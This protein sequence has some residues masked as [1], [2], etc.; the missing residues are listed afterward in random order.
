LD[1]IKTGIVII[2]RETKNIVDANPYAIEMIGESKEKI[3]GS[4]CHRY[5]CPAKVGECPVIDLGK[6]IDNSEE[7]ILKGNGKE[8]PVLKT[9]SQITINGKELLL[10]SFIDITYQKKIETDLNSQRLALIEKTISQ[11]K[12]NEALMALLD[13]R[14]ID[15]KT[16]EQSMVTNLKRFVFPYLDDLERQKI[17]KDSKVYVNIIRTNIEQLISPVSRNLSGAYLDLTPTEIKVADLIRQGKSSKSI[18]AIL[19]I[20]LSTVEKHRNKIRKK[21]NIVKKKINLNT[22]LNSLA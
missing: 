18:V 4:V 7:L 15:K 21:L 16:I 12:A 11:E 1:S 2:D 10:E 3:I 19:N 14:E 13:H 17:K 6:E 8:S 5:L 22:Y 9:V 20:S